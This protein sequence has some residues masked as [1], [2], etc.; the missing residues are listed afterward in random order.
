MESLGS[1]SIRGRDRERE[2]ERERIHRKKTLLKKDILNLY[3][4]SL[5]L[6]V[7]NEHVLYKS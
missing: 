5:Y 4:C 2:R 1:R 6:R 3:V 7:F